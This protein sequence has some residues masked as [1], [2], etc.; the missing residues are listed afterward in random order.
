MDEGE[1]ETY[2]LEECKKLMTSIGEMKDLK[3]SGMSFDPRMAYRYMSKIKNAMKTAIWNGKC[4]ER[5][6]KTQSN[7]DLP[8]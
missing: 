5:F 6:V 4:Q 8:P 3:E 7:I 2:G 1:Y